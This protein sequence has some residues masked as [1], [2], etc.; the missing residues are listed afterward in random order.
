NNGSV[1][2]IDIGEQAVTARVLGSRPTPYQ[3]SVSLPTFSGADRE[4]ILATVAN[5]PVLLSRLLA[6]QLP[7]HVLAL[8]EAQ[9]VR[10]FPRRWSDLSAHCSCPD[11]A[12]PCKHIAALIYLLAGEIDRN[13]F[14]VFALRGMDLAG[15]L[16]Q[17]TGV[18]PAELTR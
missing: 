1:R 17:R 6:R 9:G 15:A 8:L 10:L 4:V 12:L 2:S 7:E 11:D 3:V 18:A 14:T 5:S 16:E 13:P